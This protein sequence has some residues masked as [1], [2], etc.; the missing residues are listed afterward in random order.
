MVA[1]GE[2]RYERR[3]AEHGEN[4]HVELY[5]FLGDVIIDLSETA[6]LDRLLSRTRAKST[7]LSPSVVSGRP[8]KFRPLAEFSQLRRQVGQA[9]TFW[10][11]MAK[12]GK[13]NDQKE[14]KIGDQRQVVD[15]GERV[16]DHVIR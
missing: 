13:S 1:E 6:R 7:H 5:K 11:A 4:R 3:Y 16:T 15:F 9:H 14:Y 8:G 10:Q 2:K 12:R